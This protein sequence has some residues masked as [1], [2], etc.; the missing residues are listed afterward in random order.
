MTSKVD[1]Q[2]VALARAMEESAYL[3]TQVITNREWTLAH[4]EDYDAALAAAKDASAAA[5]QRYMDYK[6][7]QEG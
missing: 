7:S 1:P 4:G 5:R 6:A 3:V 2:A